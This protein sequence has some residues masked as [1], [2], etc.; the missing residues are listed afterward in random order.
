[1]VKS[2]AEQ[3]DSRKITVSAMTASD[4]K[5]SKAQKK[6]AM[7]LKTVQGQIMSTLKTLAA[8]QPDTATA[9]AAATQPTKAAPTAAAT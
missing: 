8:L 3:K 7:K 5:K 4:K 9:A 6:V 1:M 2:N